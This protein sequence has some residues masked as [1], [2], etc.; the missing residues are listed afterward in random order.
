MIE[1]VVS[2]VVENE[3][4]SEAEIL[5]QLEL[6]D[7]YVDVDVG[8]NDSVDELVQEL[9]DSVLELSV[10]EGISVVVLELSEVE[11]LVEVEK[12]LEV[13]ELV[14][15]ATTMD[16]SVVTLDDD[17]EDENEEE[18]EVGSNVLLLEDSVEVLAIMV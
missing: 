17:D 12:L 15:E 6:M 8:V 14:G 4:G 10:A 2:L 7:V 13:K 16:V 11:A 18:D 5:V 1:V 3:V 9:L